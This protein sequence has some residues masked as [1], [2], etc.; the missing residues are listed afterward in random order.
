VAEGGLDFGWQVD[1]DEGAEGGHAR[2]VVRFVKWLYLNT[3]DRSS[4]TCQ[5]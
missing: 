5:V 4:E 3:P 1:V 2:I